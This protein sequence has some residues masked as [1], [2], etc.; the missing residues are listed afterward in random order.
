MRKGVACLESRFKQ[1]TKPARSGQIVGTLADLNRS[2]PELIAENMF[3][4]QQLLI[5]QRQVDRP[6]L[7]Q[8]DR[9][10]LVLL[11]SRIRAWRHALLIVKPD[12]LLGWHRQGFKLIWRRKSRN[13]Q[14]RPPLDPKVVELIER[15]AVSNRTWRAERIQGELLKLG[16][17]VS[18]GTVRKY[19]RRARKGLPSLNAGQNWATFIRNHAGETWACDFLQTYNLFFCQHRW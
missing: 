18:R 9:Q 3:L 7:T 16:F 12:T 2:K 1:W 10:I 11:A 19:M 8:R 6:K 5:L 14:G 13:R 17:T 4:R 15:M